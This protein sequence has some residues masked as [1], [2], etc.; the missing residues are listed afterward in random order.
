MGDSVK[1]GKLYHHQGQSPMQCQLNTL[2][3]AC[4]HDL[5][6]AMFVSAIRS[7]RSVSHS[8]V[9]C[10]ARVSHAARRRHRPASGLTFNDGN[11]DPRQKGA[12][13]QRMPGQIYS[14]YIFGI[15]LKMA[16]R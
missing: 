12:G 1:M 4:R 14:Y 10:R 2:A 11:L 9:S 8:R 15:F 5:S 16:Y 7:N 6:A 3:A 13:Q